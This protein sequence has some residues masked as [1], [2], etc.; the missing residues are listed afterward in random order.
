MGSYLVTGGCGFIGSH[1]VDALWRRGHNVRI[2]D[3][4]STGKL[5]HKP[6]AVEFIRGDIAEP[7]IV[8]EAMRGVDGCFHLAAVASVERGN[9]DWLGTHRTNLTGTL[10]VFNAARGT[11]PEKPVPI[12]FASSAAVYGANANIPLSE[13]DVP[14]PLS[15][16]GADKLGCELYGTVAG[17]VHRVPSCGLRL[18]NVYGPRQDSTSPYSGVICIFCDRLKA[19]PEITVYGDGRQT[20]DFI[21]VGDV[22]RGLLMA[23]EH[24]SPAGDIFNICTGVATAI[25]DLAKIIGDILGIKPDMSFAPSRP[26]DIYTSLGNPSKAWRSLGFAAETGLIAGLERT[27]AAG[28]KL[29]AR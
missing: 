20:R 3:D 6:P 23:M 29:T 9:S 12:V 8:T 26:G 13:K 27:L 1:L 10:T 21:Y 17:H 7:S 2:I 19:G 28:R 11:N 4:L 15:A 16:Y 24:C 22:I 14:R 25:R 18:F 5:A